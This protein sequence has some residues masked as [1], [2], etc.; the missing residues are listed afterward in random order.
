MKLSLFLILS[1]VLVSSLFAD[2]RPNILFAFA[3]DW[4]RYASAYEALDKRSSPNSVVKTRNF[5]RIADEGVLFTNAFV[6]APSCTPC[7][8]SLLSGQYFFRTGL[9]AILQ[10][11]VWDDSIPSFPLML[12]DAG[13]HIGQTYKVWS[14]G[15]VKDAPFGARKYEYESAGTRFNQFSQNATKLM[16]AGSSLMDAKRE[17]YDEVTGNFDSFIEAQPEDAPFCYW[18]GPTNVHRKWTRGSGKTLWGLDPDDLKGKLP[19]FLPDVHDVREDMVDYLGEVMAFDTA[20][21]ILLDRLAALG[22]LENTIVVVSG[23]HGIPGFTHAK[24]NLY[25]FGTHVSLAIRWPGKGKPGRVVT[26]FVNLMDLAPTFLEVGGV[27]PPE[28][29]TGRSLVE[30]MKSKGQGRVDES[31]DFV[32]TGRERHVLK[33]REGLLPYPHRALRTDDFLYIRNFKP[34]RWPAG[35]PHDQESGKPFS[36]DALTNNTFTTFADMDAGPTKAWLVMNADTKEGKRYYDF[37]FGKRP[38][39]ELY[40]LKSDPDQV[41][42]LASDKRYAS[43]RKELSERLITTLRENG[44]PR[45][46][47]DGSTFDKAPYVLAE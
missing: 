47:G 43:I 24:T 22:E 21:G 18:F 1:L 37:A 25:D 7:R 30:I 27:K 6:N 19:D 14:P 9:G 41:V 38:G 34:N 36:K 39:E 16:D 2:K 5:D 29:M 8:S 15:S 40:D 11:A 44:D 45:V 12:R 46:Q 28:V 42:N 13:Y 4:G 23:D 20:L 35:N 3:D 33:A 31:R 10:G 32:V 17:L 26:D